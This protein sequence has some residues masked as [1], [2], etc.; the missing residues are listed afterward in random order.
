MI[1]P[2]IVSICMIT[3]NHENYL[4]EAID[5]VLIQKTNFKFQLVIG[6]DCSSDGTREI[7]EEYANKYPDKIKLLEFSENLGMLP[8]FIRTLEACKGKYIA[9]CEGDD[10]WTDSYKLQK[11]VDFLEENSDYS[12]SCH[13]VDILFENTGRLNKT[14]YRFGGTITLKQ[15]LENRWTIIHTASFVFRSK[16]MDKYFSKGLLNHER[17]S[18]DKYLFAYITSK[19]KINSIEEVMS[20]YRKND[21]G[22][23]NNII[24]HNHPKKKYLNKIEAYRSFIHFYKGIDKIY[25]YKKTNLIKRYILGLKIDIFFLKRNI[26]ENNILSRISK[27]V[28]NI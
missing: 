9:L 26:P 1:S 3:Y 21:G 17:Q 20:I 2:P 14:R 5:G 7:C 16:Y 19:G 22:V 18:G 24:N 28:L 11:Q 27:K 6:E 12:G 8:N 25:E 15:I 23:T 4:S 13:W 10:Y